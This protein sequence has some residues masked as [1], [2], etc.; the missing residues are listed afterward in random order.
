MNIEDFKN[1][2]IVPELPPEEEPVEEPMAPEHPNTPVL[3]NFMMNEDEK[4][5]ENNQILEHILTKL[6]DNSDKTIEEYQ[7]L[8][9]SEVVE[10]LKKLQE[11]IKEDHKWEVNLVIE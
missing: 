1:R 11:I 5:S 7:L 4:F 8:K 10:E 9:Q 6:D 2:T 3:E